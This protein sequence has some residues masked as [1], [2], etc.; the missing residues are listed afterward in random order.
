MNSNVKYGQEIGENL[1][2][3][4]VITLLYAILSFINC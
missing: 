4:T 3:I 1:I 2:T